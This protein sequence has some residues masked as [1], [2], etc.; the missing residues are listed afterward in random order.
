MAGDIFTVHGTGG[1]AWLATHTN[2]NAVGREASSQTPLFPSPSEWVKIESLHDLGSRTFGEKK[3]GVIQFGS[4]LFHSLSLWLSSSLSLF[5]CSLPWRVA[6]QSPCLEQTGRHLPR[7]KR[8]PPG[9]HY[10]ARNFPCNAL[11]S[12]RFSLRETPLEAWPLEKV[13]T[14]YSTH[15]NKQNKNKNIHKKL[16]RS[17]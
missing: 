6:G 1:C 5:A 7:L 12:S 16:T 3:D 8:T 13:S 4:Q 14:K 10:P 17:C 11:L 2:F 15:Q 9:M